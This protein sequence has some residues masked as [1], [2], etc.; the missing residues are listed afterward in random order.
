MVSLIASAPAPWTGLFF[1]AVCAGSP[2]FIHTGSLRALPIG[3]ED[4]STPRLHSA[5]T[6]LCQAASS[7]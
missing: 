5:S 1:A 4:V 7:G 2:E 6:S 3:V